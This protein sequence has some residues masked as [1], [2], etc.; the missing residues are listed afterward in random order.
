LWKRTTAAFGPLLE[1][2]PAQH[3]VSLF[4]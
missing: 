2:G 1:K 3:S 4:P